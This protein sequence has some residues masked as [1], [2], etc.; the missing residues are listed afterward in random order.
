MLELQQLISQRHCSA[1]SGWVKFIA[2]R[3]A[4]FNWVY[5]PPKDHQVSGDASI[6]GSDQIK[7]GKKRLNLG[8]SDDLARCQPN[9]PLTRSNCSPDLIH[10]VAGALTGRDTNNGQRG[11]G[12]NGRSNS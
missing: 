10:H 12:R 9:S 2:A 4:L 5:G 6:F 3:S 7:L 8:Y 1:A 11:R